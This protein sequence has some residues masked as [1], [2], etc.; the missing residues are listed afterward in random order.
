MANYYRGQMTIFDYISK[1]Q[2]LWEHFRDN[3][4]S[5]Q[6][7]ILRFDNDGK[8]TG[9]KAFEAV[10]ACCFTPN[11]IKEPWDNWQPCTFDE[12]PFLK[13]IKE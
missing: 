11:N 6:G 2:S 12:C 1:D 8:K 7:G 5:K 9:D 4:C 13:E 10:K 3:Y